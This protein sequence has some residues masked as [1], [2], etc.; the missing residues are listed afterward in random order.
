MKQLYFTGTTNPISLFLLQRT[1]WVKMCCGIIGKWLDELTTY[2]TA[3]VPGGCTKFIQAP[4]VLEETIQRI[5]YRDVW[6]VVSKWCSPV[7]RSMKHE[8]RSTT[9][10]CRMDFK[11]WQMLQKDLIVNSFHGCAV[12]LKSDGS[13]DDKIHCFK[14]KGPCAAGA[15]LLKDQTTLLHDKRSWKKI[16]LMIR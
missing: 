3:L 16:P 1:V 11:A 10:R 13:K 5:H 7:H 9:S 15:A 14:E 12:N 4:D 8:V 2:N 6:R